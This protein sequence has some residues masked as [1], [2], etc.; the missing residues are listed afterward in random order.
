LFKVG[1][2]V[3]HTQHFP[4]EASINRGR[5][6]PETHRFEGTADGDAEALN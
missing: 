3:Q 1:S 4:D 5:Y 2:G 6:R